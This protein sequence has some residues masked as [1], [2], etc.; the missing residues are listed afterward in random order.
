MAITDNRLLFSS[1]T[2]SDSISFSTIVSFDVC[3]TA[4]EVQ[5][6]SKAT[7]KFL[8]E[9]DQQFAGAI[10]QIAVALA[11]QT[12][13]RSKTGSNTRHIPREIRQ[14]VWQRYCGQCADCGASNYLEFDHIVPVAK[15]GS[16]SDANVQLLCR[17]CNLQKS[18]MI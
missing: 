3:H 9:Q 12:L 6:K 2:K 5:A 18:D 16:N 8:S 11:N 1:P 7:T 14:R 13:V 10:F 15:G 4:I 17:K